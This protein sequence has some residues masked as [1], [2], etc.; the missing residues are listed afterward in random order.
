MPLNRDT[1]TR[2]SRI[3]LPAYVAF[4]AGIGLNYIATPDTRLRASPALGYAATLMPLP[5]WGG[6]FLA[7]A[8]LMAVALIAQRRTLYRYALLLCGISMTVWTVAMAVAALY[9]AT[10]PGAWL[11]PGFVVAACAASYRSL[12]TGEAD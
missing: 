3:M 8:A 1:V 7:A 6:L 9:S 10:T 11:W 4:F 2:A 5:A 12:S